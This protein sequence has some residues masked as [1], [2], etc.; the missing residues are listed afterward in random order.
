MVDVE[1]ATTKARAEAEAATFALRY[2]VYFVF[3]MFLTRGV[4]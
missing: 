1:R 3:H 4:K 2:P